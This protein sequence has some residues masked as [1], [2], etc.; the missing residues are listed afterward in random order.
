MNNKK[1]PLE[2]AYNQVT[3]SELQKELLH[4]TAEIKRLSKYPYEDAEWTI[5]PRA[6][7]EK[8]TKLKERR[9]EILALLKLPVQA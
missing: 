2:E 9:E 4:I 7:I 6:V 5:S 1:C 3:K 8:R